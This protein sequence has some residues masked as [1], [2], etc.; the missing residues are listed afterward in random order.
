MTGVG[1]ELTPSLPAAGSGRARRGARGLA[2]LLL[3]L[4]AA[5]GTAVAVQQ[6]DVAAQ[7]RE[8]ARILEGQRDEAIGRTEALGAQLDELA[9]LVRG[10]TDDLT[11]L[12]QRLAELAEEKARAEDRATVTR[13]ELATLAARVADAVTRLDRCVLD[14]LDLQRDTVDAFNRLNSGER[15]DVSPLNDRL[16]VV[17]AACVDAVNAGRA[18][19]ALAAQ[20]R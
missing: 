6:R 20:L 13:D 1:T 16:A 11:T 15:V 8:R 2:M 4:L 14:L 5:G 3:V 12:E 17:R 10:S 19:A 7:W 9:D 18:A